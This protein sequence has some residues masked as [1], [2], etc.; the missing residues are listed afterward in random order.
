[1][2]RLI[3]SAVVGLIITLLFQAM[4][5]GI[6][7]MIVGPPFAFHEGT[8][9]VTLGWMAI[10]LPLTFGAAVLG[11]WGA[12]ITAQAQKVKAVKWAAIVTF[13]FFLALPIFHLIIT[14]KP[15]P[16]APSELGTYEA[17]NY[18]I[19]PIWY[20]LIVP[21]VAAAGNMIGGRIRKY[22]DYA[23]WKRENMDE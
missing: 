9:N 2:A 7:W 12:A 17:A 22:T 3:A 19:Q 8:T 21:F 16:V 11:G 6:A 5:L 23:A 10:S 1:M 14:R 4:L 15:P 13:V 20:E 18:A